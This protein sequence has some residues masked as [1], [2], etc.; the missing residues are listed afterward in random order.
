M[1]FDISN[2]KNQSVAK[3]E[4]RL[5][6]LVEND[7]ENE[8]IYTLLKR[9]AYIYINQNKYVYGYSG[10]EDVCHDVAADT[11]MAVLN[12]RRIHAWIYYIGRMIKLSY[13]TRQRNIEHE[14]IDASDNIELKEGIKRMC[15]SSSISCINDFD[16]MERNLMLDNIG[17]T[18]NETMNHIKFKRGTREWS[19]IYLNVSMNLLNE[20]D[21]KPYSY[22]RIDDNLKPYV[23]LTI[24]QFKRQFSNSGFMDSVMYNVDDDLDMQLREQND[25]KSSR[26][27]E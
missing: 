6:Y 15:A 26:F 24:A 22:L 19:Q 18:I 5:N 16:I 1:T 21:N 7:I 23:Q 4:E 3:I 11:W 8:E 10:I 13:V 9:L 17:N 2:K 27:D 14:I 20:L 12:G 25:N